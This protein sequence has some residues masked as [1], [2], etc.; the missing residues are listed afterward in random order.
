MS[1][2]SVS[3]I[4]NV[5]LVSLGLWLTLCPVLNHAFILDDFD[6]ESNDGP[7]FNGHVAA[8]S[9]TATI[10]EHKH[11]QCS[12]YG[13][14][15]LKLGKLLGEGS[16][17]KV[18][19]T[20]VKDIGKV[21]VKKFQNNNDFKMESG[22]LDVL[23][24][25]TREGTSLNVYRANLALKTAVQPDF[26]YG[27]ISGLGSMETVLCLHLFSGSLSD[28]MQL[29]CPL[30]DAEMLRIAKGIAGG[31][32]VLREVGIVHRDLKLNNIL[33][34]LESEDSIRVAEAA[35]TDFG[36]AMPSRGSSLELDYI[37]NI[38]GLTYGHHAPECRHRPTSATN[39][40]DVFSFGVV[41]QQILANQVFS[42]MELMVNLD[43]PWQMK[44]PVNSSPVQ[45]FLRGLA[46]RC[47]RKH[48]IKRPTPE[49]IHREIVEVMNEHGL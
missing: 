17:G 20:E 15:D 35:I 44:M 34:N 48:A 41:L 28:R 2:V 14:N 11:D 21:A 32:I 18:Q 45:I 29:P 39:A 42:Y 16:Y 31:L 5:C 27:M 43:M 30:N 3:K 12:V 46:V 8:V 36:L 7:E 37:N 33:V 49:Q 9:P 13:Y 23:E 40:S 38:A 4:H 1:F 26:D 6:F 19:E 10:D 47:M 25:A 24:L 22:F